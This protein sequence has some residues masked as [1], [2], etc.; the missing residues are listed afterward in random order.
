MN[1]PENKRSGCR[2]SGP[3]ILTCGAGE[4]ENNLAIV[5]IIEC[6]DYNNAT[7]LPELSA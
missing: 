5:Y 4:I 2:T 1:K 6:K 3:H 7:A